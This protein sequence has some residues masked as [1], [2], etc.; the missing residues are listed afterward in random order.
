MNSL[1]KEC[2]VAVFYESVMGLSRPLPRVS[3][4]GSGR[5]VRGGERER[6]ESERMRERERERE[7]S[8]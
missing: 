5:R 4:Q 8:L 7:S 3:C 6:R 1:Y 2:T